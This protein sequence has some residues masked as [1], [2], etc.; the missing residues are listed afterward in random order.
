MCQAWLTDFYFFKST[1]LL[2]DH[3]SSWKLTSKRRVLSQE[4]VNELFS[5]ED[6]H[7][8]E[9]KREETVKEIKDVTPQ[10]CMQY[11]RNYIKI[12]NS[13][14]NNDTIT[15]TKPVEQQQV[16]DIMVDCK[17]DGWDSN[18]DTIT[19][20]RLH[21]IAS[22]LLEYIEDAMKRAEAW[23][24][25]DSEA[26]HVPVEIDGQQIYEQLVNSREAFHR[27]PEVEQDKQNA[28]LIFNFYLAYSSTIMKIR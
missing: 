4:E 15:K 14:C 1:T 13:F 21:D 23:L 3:L 26:S 27:L 5:N 11:L 17:L 25:S 20:D 16:V 7:E 8:R 19:F 6:E 28:G 22:I 18:E 9:H 10:Y 24:R 2:N 12:I